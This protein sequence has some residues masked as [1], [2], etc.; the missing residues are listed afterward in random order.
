MR[1]NI[2]SFRYRC[3]G[4][5]ALKRLHQLTHVRVEEDDRLLLEGY[6]CDGCGGSLAYLM[7]MQ[8]FSKWRA[9]FRPP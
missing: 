7:T 4:C 2:S 1:A 6:V 9:W 8:A 5:N 3:E